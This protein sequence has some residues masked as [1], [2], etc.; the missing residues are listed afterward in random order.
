MRELGARRIIGPCA[1]GALQA[2]LR[3]GEFVVCDQ[4]VDRTCGRSDTF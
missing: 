4:F 3:L 1:S 2:D